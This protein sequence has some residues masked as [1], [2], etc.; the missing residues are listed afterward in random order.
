MPEEVPLAVQFNSQNY[1]VM[2][3]T[4]ADFEDFAVGFAIAEASNGQEAVRQVALLNPDL[5]LMDLSM[6]LMDG[7]ETSRMIRRICCRRAWI[8]G[9][10]LGCGSLMNPERGYRA[11]FVQLVETARSLAP[12]GPGAA[13]PGNLQAP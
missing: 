7:W 3:G 13:R 10:F 12:K 2:M 8:R 11:E 1:A 9:A 5:I 4:P 6:P